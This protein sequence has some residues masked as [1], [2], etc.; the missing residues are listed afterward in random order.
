MSQSSTG[1]R[2][3][4]DARIE[5]SQ[6]TLKLHRH[7]PHELVL[8]GHVSNLVDPTTQRRCVVEI[9][10][11]PVSVSPGSREWLREVIEE[12]RTRA[13]DVALQK[14][15]DDKAGGSASAG[16]PRASRIT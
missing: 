11:M 6:V 10:E 13:P 4:L 8:T 15:R 12:F 14:L 1:E 9:R 2:M 16:A 7:H 5:V 3:I